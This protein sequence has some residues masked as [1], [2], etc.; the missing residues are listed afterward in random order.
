[1]KSNMPDPV[2][3]IVREQRALAI[4]RITNRQPGRTS[5]ECVLSECLK[6]F[7]LTCGHEELRAEIDALEI[8]VTPAAR[9]ASL[10]RFPVAVSRTATFRLVD[11]TG[12]PLP[13][14]L[15]LRLAGQA[16]TFPLGLD[17]KGY[18]T[19]LTAGG[20]QRLE[21]AGGDV[22]C[23]VMLQLP[24]GDAEMPDL[25]TLVCRSVDRSNP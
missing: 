16:R 2:K 9:S 24:A 10:I 20:P 13:A 22:R 7:G 23:G 4:L 21:V 14:G 1:M 6:Q 5:N 17:G 25:G 8:Q 15:S 12:Q 19:G 11:E 18:V 3:Q